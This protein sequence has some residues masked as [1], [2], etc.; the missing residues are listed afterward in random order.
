MKVEQY[1]DPGELFE[2]ILAIFGWAVWVI[3]VAALI[4]LAVLP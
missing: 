1:K 4:G 2:A 3:A